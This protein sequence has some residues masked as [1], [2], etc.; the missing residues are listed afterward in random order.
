[1]L[2]EIWDDAS[3]LGAGFD[4]LAAIDRTLVRHGSGLQAIW[5]DYAVAEAR[6]DFTVASA[7]QSNAVPVAATV[8]AGTPLAVT[9]DHFDVGYAAIRNVGSAA[10]VKGSLRVTVA[11]AAGAGAQPAF[12]RFLG[13]SA[14]KRPLWERPKQLAADASGASAVIPWSACTDSG[15]LVLPNPS[16]Q[17]GVTFTVS[18]AFSGPASCIVPQLSGLSSDDARVA[19]NDAG[20]ALYR[21]LLVPSPPALKRRTVRQSVVAGAKVPGGTKVTIYLGDGKQ[22]GKR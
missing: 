1:M 18:V 17:D 16:R 13:L 15:T 4:P 9:L 6:N 8:A 14:D 19:L 10:C 12:T 21:R 2:G 5:N 3:A 11:F 22:R 20:C 7:R